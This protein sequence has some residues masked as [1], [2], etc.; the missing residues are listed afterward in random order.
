MAFFVD[1]RMM[2]FTS[3]RDTPNVRA[4]VG[5]FR[6]ASN[7][8]RIRFA[9]PSGSSATSVDSIRDCVGRAAMGADRSSVLPVEVPRFRLAIS[10]STA[11]CSR[12]RSECSRYRSAVARSR[13]SATG[14]LD[15][16][17]ADAVVR[18]G[19]V[20]FG[21]ANECVFFRVSMD[22]GSYAD[23][24]ADNATEI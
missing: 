20:S 10:T 9:F 19:D 6:P 1:E 23:Q 24:V 4:M 22:R 2:R 18:A 15:G 3:E 7:D 21:P 14:G 13:G 8:A 16:V 11:A 12:C 5:A 17:S